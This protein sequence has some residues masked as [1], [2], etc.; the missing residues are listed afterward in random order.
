METAKGNNLKPYEYL[1]HVLR[2]MPGID[3]TS[4]PDRLELLLPWSH[5]LPSVC[6]LNQDHSNPSVSEV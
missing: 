5:H 4:E 6:Y 2:S 1:L 3:Y